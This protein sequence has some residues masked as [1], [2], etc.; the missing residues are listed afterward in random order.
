MLRG[1]DVS[2]LQGAIDVPSLKA[3]GIAFLIVKGAEGD[4][5]AP[6]G[7]EQADVDACDA[8][9]LPVGCYLFPYPLPPKPGAPLHDPVAQARHHFELVGG[10]GMKNGHL[11]PCVDFEW[12]P[13]QAWS[14]WGC[15]AAQLRDWLYIYLGE[16]ERLWGV[17]P[18]LYLYRYFAEALGIA[19]D[20]RFARFQL[21][22]A[23]Y[24]DAKHWPADGQT[25]RVPAP[26]KAALFWQTAG[27]TNMR[28]PSGVPIDTDVFLGDEAELRALCYRAPAPLPVAPIVDVG[29]DATAPGE[30]P[31]AST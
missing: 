27:G 21:W 1:C 25:P 13:P 14:T 2:S 22:M 10:L 16:V 23:D 26:W 11:P 31:G 20:A 4:K 24:E 9:G 7:R 19:N 12:P 28:L 30:L 3:S 6:D 17:S 15:S 18:L 5:P 29:A 8:A